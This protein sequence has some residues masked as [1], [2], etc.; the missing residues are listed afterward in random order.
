MLAVVTVVD[1]GGDARRAPQG[2]IFLCLAHFKRLTEQHH[3]Y[4][5]FWRLTGQTPWYVPCFLSLVTKSRLVQPWR[6][7]ASES[8]KG[9]NFLKFAKSGMSKCTS[10]IIIINN[11]II[12]TIIIKCMYIHHHH[13]HHHHH[14]QHLHHRHHH[15]IRLILGVAHL[16]PSWNIL[17]R[18][19]GE[20]WSLME[21]RP[22]F[23]PRETYSSEGVANFDP[24]WR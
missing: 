18:G 4:R 20:F 8:G 24:S 5:C 11:N 7:S 22:V 15:D 6:C 2:V 17:I 12:I 21:I 13:H 14:H 16:D 3:K 23:F 19:G 9:C 1:D 10:F